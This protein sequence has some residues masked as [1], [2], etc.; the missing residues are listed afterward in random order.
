MIPLRHGMRVCHR[1]SDLGVLVASTIANSKTKGANSEVLADKSAKTRTEE[2]TSK[3]QLPMPDAK[4]TL[5]TM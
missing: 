4:E 1:T 3:E 5:H 2:F